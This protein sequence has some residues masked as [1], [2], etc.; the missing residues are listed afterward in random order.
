MGG[1]A[2]AGT[3]T[4]EATIKSPTTINEIV[5]QLHFFNVQPPLKN[6]LSKFSI[7]PQAKLTHSDQRAL[8]GMAEYEKGFPTNNNR[9]FPLKPYC[10]ASFGSFVK[11]FMEER[12][13]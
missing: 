13:K 5:C 11:D 6:F 2:P 10:Q 7:S 9:L 8:R 4:P 3:V 12:K 1:W